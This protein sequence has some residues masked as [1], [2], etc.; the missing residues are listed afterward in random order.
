MSLNQLAQFHLLHALKIIIL[1]IMEIVF[2]MSALHLILKKL[3]QMVLLQMET[4][5]V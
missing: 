2:Q 4:V 5:D 1:T 3:V